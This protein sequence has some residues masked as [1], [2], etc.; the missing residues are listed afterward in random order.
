[1][2]PKSTALIFEKGKMVI[3]GTKSVEDA[4][5]ASEKVIFLNYNEKSSKKISKRFV[6]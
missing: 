3:T 1:V 4:K 6:K 5:V 2:D